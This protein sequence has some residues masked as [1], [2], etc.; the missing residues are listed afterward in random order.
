VE[1]HQAAVSDKDGKLQFLAD[2]SSQARL[3]SSNRKDTTM[4]DVVTLDSLF[5]G[6]RIDILKIDVEGYEEMVF[7][8]ANRLLHT[9]ELK[10]RAIF[11]EVH[12]YAWA[13]L[14][15]GSDSLL[16]ALNEAGYLVETPDGVPIRS[17]ERYGEIIAR[18]RS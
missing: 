10:P 17:I 9:P 7:R 4:V 18:L 8:G 1:L 5:E 14:R 2:G 13:P 11:V 12:P 15:T 6:R 16:R 3:V